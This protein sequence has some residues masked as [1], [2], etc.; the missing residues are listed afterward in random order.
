[1]ITY[2]EECG[3]MVKMPPSQ[4]NR[5]EH[6]FCSRACHMVYMNRE[7][8]TTRMTDEVGAKLREA[9]I[10]TGAENTAECIRRS[11]MTRKTVTHRETEVFV[12]EEKLAPRKEAIKRRVK[13]EKC[14]AAGINLGAMILTGGALVKIGFMVFTVIDSRTG[15][16]G[17]EILV[18][19]AL[20]MMFLWGREVGRSR[21]G[22]RSY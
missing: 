22:G 17:G 13:L 20:A 2:C 19:P 9:R 8:N 4:F 16:L 12:V 5:A 1:M 3:V 7:L 14:I 18:F 21:A 6:H 11:N 10:G 15:G